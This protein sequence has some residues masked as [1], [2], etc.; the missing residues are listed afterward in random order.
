[1]KCGIVDL[2]TNSAR[3]FIFERDQ[4]GNW[5]QVYKER[6]MVRLGD[7]L[8]L[9]NSIS[10][11]AFNRALEAFERFH[12]VMNQHAVDYSKVIATSALREAVDSARLIKKV[13][14]TCGLKVE[15]ISGEQEAAYVAQGV[16]S[17]TDISDDEVVL[18]DIGGG[19]VEIVL[20][21]DNQ[22]LTLQSLNLGAGKAQQVLLKSVPPEPA[23]VLKMQEDLRSSLAKHFSAVSLSESVAYGIG[24]SGSIRALGRIAT[25]RGAYQSGGFSAEFLKSLLSEIKGLSIDELRVLPQLE[26]RRADLIV[27]ATIILSEIMDFFKINLMKPSQCSL[28]DGVLEEL[29]S[30]EPAFQFTE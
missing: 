23:A 12:L 27:A 18:V 5:S 22:V 6:I 24:T 2:G 15:V 26:E 9:S 20:C 14:Q 17:C 30:D 4:A 19:S 10:E 11:I 28:V 29:V 1:M 21:R 16:L 8:F 7:D 25:D 13:D 3:L